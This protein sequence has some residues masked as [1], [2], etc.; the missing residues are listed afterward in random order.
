[1]TIPGMDADPNPH[2]IQL[3]DVRLPDGAT[4]DPEPAETETDT[5]AENET[6]EGGVTDADIDAVDAL[7]NEVEQSLSRLDAGTYGRCE[8]CGEPIDD[9]RLAELP[10]ARTCSTCPV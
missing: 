3:E 2:D 8:E 5:D 9:A 1:G 7:L 6:A 10:T 4:A